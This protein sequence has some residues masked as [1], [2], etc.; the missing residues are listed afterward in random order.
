MTVLQRS[1]SPFKEDN[2]MLYV[3]NNSSLLIT[4]SSEVIY[5]Q[6]DYTSIGYACKSETKAF[7]IAGRCYKP[8]VM[9]V[10]TIR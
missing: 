2:T 6:F 8:S 5:F 10:S 7:V 4:I 9:M 3:K 1:Q